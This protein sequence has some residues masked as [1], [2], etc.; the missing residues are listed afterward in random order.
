MS[1]AL[2]PIERITRGADRFHCPRLHA[3][4][5]ADACL[6]R[7]D[8]VHEGGRNDRMRP[9]ATPTHPAC[10]ACVLGRQV[11]AQVTGEGTAATAP[12][13]TSAAQASP[14]APTA[15]RT[16]AVAGCPNTVPEGAAVLTL[17]D[18]CKGDWL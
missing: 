16:C 11:R 6:A 14:P 9:R 18:A 12:M 4:L 1:A 10:V 5:T 2:V 7:Q 13:E 17:C 8:A 3:N 15:T